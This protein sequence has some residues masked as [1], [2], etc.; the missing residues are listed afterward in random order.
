[1][2][3]CCRFNAALKTIKVNDE[4]DLWVKL[5]QCNLKDGKA[6]QVRIVA[7]AL[8]LAGTGCLQEQE[9]NAFSHVLT[10]KQGRAI[11]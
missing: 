8:L 10:S 6:K 3:A 2:H 9:I 1:M 5:R 7:F 11:D 4:D